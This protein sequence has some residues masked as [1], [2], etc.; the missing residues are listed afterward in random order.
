[1]S[2]QWMDLVPVKWFEF[3]HTISAHPFCTECDLYGEKQWELAVEYPA[4]MINAPWPA[5]PDKDRWV[6]MCE[7]CFYGGHEE[8]HPD[9]SGEEDICICREDHIAINCPGCF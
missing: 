1:M 2:D 9:Y 7:E 6:W 3:K 4:V 5:F 8:D